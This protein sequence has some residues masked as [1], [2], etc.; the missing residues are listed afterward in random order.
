LT[1]RMAAA[2]KLQGEIDKSL[3]KIEEGIGDFDATWHKVASAPTAALKEKYETDLKKEVR[4]C[5]DAPHAAYTGYRYDAGS[6][7]LAT[8]C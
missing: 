8:A 5:S 3:K 2:R 6:Y 4:S 7:V 1:G